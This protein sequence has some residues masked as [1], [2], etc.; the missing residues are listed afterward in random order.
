LTLARH[1]LV[2]DDTVLDDRQRQLLGRR[3][4]SGTRVGRT[5]QRLDE[6]LS[7]LQR[8]LATR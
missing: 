6:V 3:R 7:D 1:G 2:L 8:T 4:A 5:M